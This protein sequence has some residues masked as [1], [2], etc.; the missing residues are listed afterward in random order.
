MRVVLVFGCFPVSNSVFSETL[1]N[2]AG[3]G[4]SSVLVEGNQVC[5]K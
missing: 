5:R 1:C 2:G 3:S 4:A